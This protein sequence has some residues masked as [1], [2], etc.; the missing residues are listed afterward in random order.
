MMSKSLP[1][2]Q[3]IALAIVLVTGGRAEAQAPPRLELMPRVEDHTSMW[4]VDGFP[5]TVKTASWRRCI[6]TG[7]YAFVLD[8]ETLAIPHFGA[9]PPGRQYRWDGRGD[10]QIWQELE[11]AKLK[12]TLTLEG[13]EY[14][15]VSGGKWSRFKGPR[16]IESGRFLHRD[17]VTDL[18]FSSQDGERLDV[19]ARFEVVAWPERLAL[20]L[21]ARPKERSTEWRAGSMGIRLQCSRGELANRIDLSDPPEADRDGWREVFL[22][23]NPTSFERA[24]TTSQVGVRAIEMPKGSERPVSYAPARGWHRIDLDRIEPTLPGG[25]SADRNDSIERVKLVLSNAGAEEQVARLLFAKG[26]GGIRQGVGS[27]ITGVSAILRDPDGQPTG[28]PVQLSKNWH[29][30]PEG[31]VYAGTW[32]HGFSLVRVPAGATVELELALVYGHWGGVPAASHSQLSLIGWGS[33]QH[34][35]QSAIGAWGESIC[36]EPDQVQA[37]C[38]VTDVRPLMVN[39]GGGA[40]RWRWTAN[41]GGG[42]FF[43]LFDRGGN[44]VPPSAMR[45]FYHRQGP[46]LTE[47]SFAGVLGEGITHSSTVSLGRTDDLVRGTYRLRL[48]VEKA[49]DFSRFVIFQI[50]ADTYSYTGERK[51]AIGDESGLSR[52]WDSQWGGD[53]YRTEPV[54]CAGRVPWVSLH[55]AVP[56]DSIEKFGAWANRGLVIRAWRARLGGKDARPW[57]A[58]R[59]VTIHRNSSSTID[60]LP[61]PGITR[62]EPGDFIEATIEHIVMPQFA[63]QYYGSNQGLRER[64]AE[65]ENTWEMIHREAVENDRRVEVSQ[66]ALEHRYPDIRVRA[67]AGHATLSLTGGLGYVPLTF[68]GLASNRGCTLIVDGKPLDQSIHGNDFWQTDFDAE[69]R[70]WSRS[71]NVPITDR[72]THIIRLVPGG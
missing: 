25:E 64:L 33:N 13:K 26:A 70:E 8:T 39:A 37:R 55:E 50:G 49:T 40:K 43:R 56:R 15:C 62:L 67:D 34:W 46:C 1:L 57:M 51:F 42:D 59:G 44:R 6:Q 45:T 5:G 32:F 11:P 30:R 21:A 53:R 24:A 9:I 29:T 47:V 18:V 61:P 71:Y 69:K 72:A 66:G 2:N 52:E 41:V 38:T 31:G 22:A 48:D 7:Y 60:L 35:S 23:L 28:I 27:S 54:E 63:K 36:Y 17:D 65:D 68:T 14:Q 19:E 10:R 20:V 58:E 16:L 3:I 4:W 12:L